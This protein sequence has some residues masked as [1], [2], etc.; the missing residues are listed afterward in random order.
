[1]EE[2]ESLVVTRESLNTNDVCYI[3]K[4]TNCCDK[5][6]ELTTGHVARCPVV[7]SVSL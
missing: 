2:V 1:M 4:G 6:T 7:S 3:D 5:L